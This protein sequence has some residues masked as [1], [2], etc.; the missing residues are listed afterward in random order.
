MANILRLL[1]FPKSLFS[2]FKINNGAN[3]K[4]SP[5]SQDNNK[6]TALSLIKQIVHHSVDGVLKDVE[7]THMIIKHIE[8]C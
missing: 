7:A 5:R 4:R 8:F 3:F 2:E 1:C 6:G